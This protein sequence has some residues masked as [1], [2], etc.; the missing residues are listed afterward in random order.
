MAKKATTRRAAKPRKKASKARPAR[1]STTA[2]PASARSKSTGRTESPKTAADALVDLLESP[3][4][5]D[6]LAAGAAA[7]LASF[8][9]HGLSRRHQTTTRR[10]LKEAAKAAGAAMGA[11]LSL[12]LDE[13]L[14][15]ARE[16]RREQ[17]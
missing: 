6:I 16:A 7:A 4:V 17:A 12:E 3:L 2:K 13:I 10:A 1:R 15:S 9:H 5:A 11:R 14:E 8:T